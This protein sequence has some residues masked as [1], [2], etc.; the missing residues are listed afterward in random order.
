MVK[1]SRPA[2]VTT[3]APGLLRRLRLPQLQLVRMAG[4]GANFREM[5]QALG[6]S[7]PAI[8]KMARELE[9]ALGAQVF[10]RGSSGMHLS[11]FGLAVLGHARRAL[12]AL[13]QLAD[14]LPHYHDEG[15]QALRIGS[16]AFTAAALLGG[17]VARWVNGSPG[18][19]V[20][21]SDGVSPQLLAA[22]RAG[23]LDCVI[24]SVDEGS[25]S[26]RELAELLF[27]AL[28][29]DAVTFITHPA[30]PGAARLTR[31]GQLQDMP[32]VMPP[33]A[34]QVWG[35]L[36]REFTTSGHHL[37]RGVVETS[38]I[39]AIGAIL[40]AAPGTIGAV[41]A[42][43]GRYLVRHFGLRSLRIDP[44][45]ALP[46][47][48]IMRWRAAEPS[49]HLEGFLALVRAEVRTLLPGR[50]RGRGMPGPRAPRITR[51]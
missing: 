15:T 44:P 37:P 31:L 27:E 38:S 40:R 28:Y 17:P 22:L 24:G 23:E 19:R 2:A 8:T 35:A 4:G 14:E 26:D 47:V 29:E 16:P 3:P 11:R 45:I 36:R 42:D 9:A 39:A 48:G 13:E 32:W 43:A 1:S 30:T 33:R 18:S 25:T 7:Q 49:P 21:M 34:S 50:G 46:S 20:L 5:A 10:E 51:A 6:V 12:A 41:R